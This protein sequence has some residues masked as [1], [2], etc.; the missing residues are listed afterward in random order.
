MLSK[1]N[2]DNAWEKEKPIKGQN[3]DIVRG[4]IIQTKVHDLGTVED[5]MLKFAVI[6][7]IYKEKFVFVR[8]KER[9][10]WEVP[11]GHREI[12]EA[13]DDTANR[14][15]NEETGATKFTINPILDYSVE[16]GI[17]TISYG[18]LYYA[19]IEELGKLP[20]LEIEEV[21]LFDTIPQNLTY[22]QIQ[23]ILI[24][25]LLNKRLIHDLF[26]ESER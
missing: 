16:I 22:P 14:E 1:E 6:V 2:I 15:L 25:T 9:Q 5:E 11:G 21:K 4:G 8:H 23:P 7:S 19:E 3:T 18:R 17:N 20:D 26:I 13:I 24:K 10:T 12:E